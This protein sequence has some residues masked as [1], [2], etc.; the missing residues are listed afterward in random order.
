MVIRI[1]TVIIG[2]C[3]A[4]VSLLFI[5]HK[6][7]G[8]IAVLH[9]IPG[10]SSLS[11]K[12]SS[13]IGKGDAVDPPAPAN[14]PGGNQPGGQPPTPGGTAE[15][16]PGTPPP[17]DAALTDGDATDNGQPTIPLNPRSVNPDPLNSGAT[18]LAPGAEVST[19]DPV[20]N[21]G[22]DTALAAGGSPA[23][24]TGGGPPSVPASGTEATSTGS[25]GDIILERPDRVGNGGGPTNPSGGAVGSSGVGDPS[26]AA[27][28]ADGTKPMVATTEPG[29][30]SSAVATPIVSA[31][32]GGFGPLRGSAQDTLS[33]PRRALTGYLDAS[34]WQQR[35]PLIYEGEK[36]RSKISGYYQSNPDTSLAPY[37]LELFHMEESEGPGKPYYIFF[38][39]TPD[40][41]QGFPVVLRLTPSGYK[42][43]WECFVEFHDSQFAKFHDSGEDGPKTFR[44]VMKRAPY[45]GQDRNKF[46]NL[47]DFLCYQIELP[48]TEQ[49]Y[50]AFVPRS[51]PLSLELEKKQITWG[52]P[53][54]A[55][56]LTFK[57]TM[58][59]HGVSHL[60]ITDFVSEDWHRPVD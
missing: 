18:S 39:T 3:I 24:G 28:S 55:G 15:V 9:K 14:L 30:S 23:S 7:D 32:D 37:D 36:L 47:D 59:D 49:D 8:G 25:G 4:T 33:Q 10:F 46:T 20:A 5:D 53:P 60:V 34:N 58:F 19:V 27:S 31:V 51:E 38:A 54:L 13:M 40:V 29:G 52:Q 2:I 56:M 17:S 57:R 6:Q 50:Y 22:A 42:V 21:P 45:W 43:D 1:A 26:A 41:P 11:D 44:V 35:I 12:F 48:Y 16:R